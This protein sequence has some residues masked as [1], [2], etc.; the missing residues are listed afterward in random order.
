M[1]SDDVMGFQIRVQNSCTESCT[2]YFDNVRHHIL[3][4]LV[5]DSFFNSSTMAM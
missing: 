1:A 2:T 4:N 5:I 3:L